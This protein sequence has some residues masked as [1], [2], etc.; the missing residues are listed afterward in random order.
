MTRAWSTKL[1]Q[2]VR[3]I[4]YKGHYGDSLRFLRYRLK[5]MRHCTFR[6]HAFV[7]D[8]FEITDD[9]HCVS[10]PYLNLSPENAVVIPIY[11]QG[12]DKKDPASYRPISLTSHLGKV[13][14]TIINKRLTY[15]LEANNLMSDTQAGFR[16]DRQTLDQ[17]AALENS[18]KAA[19]TN[20]RTVGAMFLDQEKA[21]DTMWREGLLMKLKS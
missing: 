5:K 14:E 3:A 20:S 11:K 15:H 13:L 18:V 16:K 8:G 12:K 9:F 4:S 6:P 2:A 17:I 21:Y 1:G 19:K 10:G 7:I